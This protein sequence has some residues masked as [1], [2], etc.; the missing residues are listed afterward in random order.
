MG[1]GNDMAGT[2][3]ENETLAQKL[4]GMMDTANAE[5]KAKVAELAMP[6]FDLIW[7]N[8]QV[9]AKAGKSGGTFAM[10]C[11]PGTAPELLTPVYAHVLARFKEGG[12]D[13][14]YQTN[15]RQEIVGVILVWKAP[16]QP[17]PRK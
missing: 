16:D 17:K 7:K 10:G 9:A 15:T 14:T 8:A 3:P 12:I 13:A 5:L 6:L 4:L 2:A 1:K 11:P